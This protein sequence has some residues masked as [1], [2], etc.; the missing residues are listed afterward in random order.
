[1][2][3]NDFSL[4]NNFSTAVMVLDDSLKIVF[5]NYQFLKTFGNIKNLERFSNY[6]SFDVCVLDS[7]NLM[8]ANPVSFAISSSENFTANAVY[9]AKDK[10]VFYLIKAYFFSDS[11]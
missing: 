1:M 9:Q 11:S 3:D 10:S 4:F 7:E 8:S 6:F 2:N 5:K